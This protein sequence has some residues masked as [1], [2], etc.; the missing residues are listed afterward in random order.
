MKTRDASEGEMRTVLKTAKHGSASLFHALWD[1]YT[2]D[3]QAF[4]C[5]SLIEPYYH[6][7]QNR[8]QGLAKKKKKKKHKTYN[9]KTHFY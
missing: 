3:S 7:L 5:I 2:S 6:E 8:N 4:L 9:H 1:I